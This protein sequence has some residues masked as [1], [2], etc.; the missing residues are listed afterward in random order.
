MRGLG[1]LLGGSWR[2]LEGLGAVLDRSWAVLGRH[3]SFLIIFDTTIC[4]DAPRLGAL[5]E[6]RWSQNGTQDGPKSKTKTKSKK[7]ALED[8][9]GAV[10]GRS[11]VV[12]GAVL[13]PKSRSRP[14]RGRD[15]QKSRF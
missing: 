5:W 12:L 1:R 4:R 14:R 8:R 3:V 15:F 11:W 13:R 9:L 2:G 7:E 10:L 6:P